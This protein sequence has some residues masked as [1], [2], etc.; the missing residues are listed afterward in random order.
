[1]KKT[2]LFTFIAITMI[3]CGTPKTVIQSKKQIKGNWNLDQISYSE[4]GDF[5]VS[6]FDVASK[7]CFEGSTWRFISNNNTGTYNLVG[8]D[9]PS[10]E[11][12]FI[13]TIVEMDQATG[14]YDF[15]LK[16]TNTKKKSETNQ[17]VR[18][19]LTLLSENAMQWQQTLN[20]E[21]KPFIISMNFSKEIE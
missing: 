2:L 12:N 11:H 17:G 16:P 15:L 14:L 3:S 19:Q 5:K 4:E 10:E 13:F 8:N 21:G 1:M 9:C 6:L 18:L 20:L 7:E